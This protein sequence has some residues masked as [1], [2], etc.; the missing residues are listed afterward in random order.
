MTRDSKLPTPGS[1]PA[2]FAGAGI[3]D[4]K[5]RRTMHRTIPALVA[6]LA[7]ALTSLGAWA[8][9]SNNYQQACTDAWDDA[10]ASS[11]STATSV[12]RVSGGPA[13][14]KGRCLITV[15]SCSITVTVGTQSET[16]AP[17]WP[18]AFSP[19]RNGIT[20][21]NTEEIDIC[22][23][24]TDSAWEATVKIGC[25]SEETDSETATADGLAAITG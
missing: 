22:F 15:T 8:D 21:A 11:Y 3:E 18:D 12:V 7:L 24:R 19:S 6:A 14:T 16:F 5:I 20:V 4:D 25:A 17:S 1:A 13:Y 23:T 9:G 10:P 2:L